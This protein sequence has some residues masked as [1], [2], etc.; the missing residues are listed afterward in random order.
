MQIVHAT[1]WTWE[2]TDNETDLGRLR[3]FFRHWETS[4]P[5][6]VSVAR[7]FGYKSAP[8]PAGAPDAGAH[9]GQP[10]ADDTGGILDMLNGVSSDG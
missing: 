1:G 9:P 6:H 8:A 2:Y 3:Q 10:P 4:P 5:V 7:F